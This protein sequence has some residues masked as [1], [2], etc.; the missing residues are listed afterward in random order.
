MLFRSEELVGLER[1]S[2]GKIDHTAAGIN[3]KDQAD[4]FCGSLYLASK[5]AEEYAYDYGENLDA[6]LD[7]NTATSDEY[8]KHQMIAEFQEELTKIYTEMHLAN[9]AMDY[10][11][12]QEYE[13]YQDIMAGIIV[14]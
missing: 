7:V 12:R 10:K 2:N 3:S 9:E 14:L 4:A 13:T 5:F 1:L 6:A 11:K 8:L